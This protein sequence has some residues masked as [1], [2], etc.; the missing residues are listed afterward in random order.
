MLEY[1]RLPAYIRFIE[2]DP[3]AGSLNDALRAHG[4]I[5]SRARTISLGHANTLSAATVH[6]RGRGAA[7]LEETVYDQQDRPLPPAA[8]G[9]ARLQVQHYRD[10]AG[11]V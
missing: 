3:P 6:R 10:L 7:D 8:N 2:K 4:L 11:K 5:P 9:Y 1:N